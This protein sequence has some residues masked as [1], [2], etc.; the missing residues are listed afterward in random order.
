MSLRDFFSLTQ[1]L[2]SQR[3]GFF[4]VNFRLKGGTLELNN[5]TAHP[6]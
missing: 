2:G 3:L 4:L 5:E 6:S 1:S